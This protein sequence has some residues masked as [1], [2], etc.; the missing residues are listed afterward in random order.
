[1]ARRARE[2]EGLITSN[3]FNSHCPI[4]CINSCSCIS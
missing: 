2:D 4:T 1:V 3:N